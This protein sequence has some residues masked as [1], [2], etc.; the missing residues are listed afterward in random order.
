MTIEAPLDAAAAGIPATSVPVNGLLTSP[1]LPT[2]LRLALPNTV[3]M[4]GTTLVAAR[5][6]GAASSGASMVMRHRLSL[7][8]Q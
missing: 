5:L 2:L 1:I 8:Q 4:L 7:R 3:A 6:A